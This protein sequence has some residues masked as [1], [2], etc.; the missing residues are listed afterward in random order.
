MA[1]DLP[2]TNTSHRSTFDIPLSFNKFAGLSDLEG[3]Y[4]DDS[5][6]QQKLTE[7]ITPND[8]KKHQ[9]GYSSTPLH[10]TKTRPTIQPQQPGITKDQVQIG[11]KQQHNDLDSEIE[12]NL[13]QIRTSSGKTT[14]G[15]S[16][17]QKTDPNPNPTSSPQNS[18]KLPSNAPPQSTHEPLSNQSMQTNNTWEKKGPDE[19]MNQNNKE[20]TQNRPQTLNQTIQPI[21]SRTPATDQATESMERKDTHGQDGRRQRQSKH[22]YPKPWKSNKRNISIEETGEPKKKSQQKTQEQTQSSN[23]KHSYH[24]LKEDTQGGAF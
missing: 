9:P 21:Q 14:S 8:H 23:Q 2:I 17:H 24:K 11:N 4:L 12:K 18:P 7:Q 19:P 6:T 20:S 5:F 22:K 1:S 13:Q 16:K 10:K 3:T 15:T